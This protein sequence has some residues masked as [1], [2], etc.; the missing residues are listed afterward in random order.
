MDTETNLYSF[1]LRFVQETKPGE[2][3]RRASVQGGANH[4]PCMAPRHHP[5]RAVQPRAP[6]HPLGRCLDFI[7]EY[8]NLREEKPMRETAPRSAS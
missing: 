2:E 7:A 8:V 5:P 1:I 3:Q 6:F 4:A